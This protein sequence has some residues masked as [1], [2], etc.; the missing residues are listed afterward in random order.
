MLVVL[1]D[2]LD[3]GNKVE[4]EEAYS[5]VQGEYHLAGELVSA[6]M[7]NFTQGGLPQTIFA[8]RVTGISF[9]S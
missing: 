7:H 1:V 5:R 4:E 6:A 8:I 9:S 2:K 3:D